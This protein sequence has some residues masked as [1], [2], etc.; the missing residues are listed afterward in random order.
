MIHGRVILDLEHTLDSSAK[1]VN[2]HLQSLLKFTVN[3]LLRFRFS[4]SGW[5]LRVGF[6]FFT[7]PP[8]PFYI[9]FLSNGQVI[10]K[11]HGL[12]FANHWCKG[13]FSCGVQVHH[14]M[15]WHQEAGEGRAKRRTILRW[16]SC[17]GE[18]QLFLVFQCPLGSGCGPLNSREKIPLERRVV[19]H[20]QKLSQRSA[21][22]S[23]WSFRLDS[24]PVDT[25]TCL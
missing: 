3:I 13:S 11:L 23:P 21:V 5:D 12:Y 25:V 20:L 15:W 14:P 18:D 17:P 6:T 16:K 9:L 1:P 2:I 19:G 22:R 24:M 8:P 4:G 10:P 7:S